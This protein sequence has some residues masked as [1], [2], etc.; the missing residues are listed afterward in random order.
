MAK[1]PKRPADTNRMAISI[2]ELAIGEKMDGSPLPDPNKG[3]NPKAVA[4][5]RVAGIK[6]GVARA[7]KLDVNQRAE[8]ARVA[9]RA[10]WKKSAG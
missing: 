8:I 1:D 6:G 3:K 4:A 2:V 9:A 7:E 10:R 5:G